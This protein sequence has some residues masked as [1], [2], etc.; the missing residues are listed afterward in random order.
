[1]KA[2][3]CVVL[4]VVACGT[5][6]GSQSAVPAPAR[7]ADDACAS[8]MQHLNEVFEQ[9]KSVSDPDGAWKALTSR[10]VEACKRDGWSHQA[11]D[12]FASI[13]TLPDLNDCEASLSEAQVHTMEAL[14]DEVAR[15]KRTPTM[16]PSPTV[17]AKATVTKYAFE[18][19]GSWAAEHPDRA[20]PERLEELLP[21]IN[22]KTTLDPWEHPYVMFCGTNVPSGVRLHGVGIKSLGPDGQPDTAD[23]ITSWE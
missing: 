3:G 15:T 21:F 14:A 7:K 20:C 1:M 5:N 23:D 18:A 6:R 13:A 9:D 17:I 11:I 10:F 19:Y 22:E 12:C 4:V 2:L 8:S 16:I